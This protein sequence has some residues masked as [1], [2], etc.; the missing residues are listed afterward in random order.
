MNLQAFLDKNR[1]NYE[2]HHHPTTYTAQGLAQVEH[3]SGFL[4]AKPVIVRG[5]S[6]YAM[7]V[8]PAP[9]HV[10]LER[11]A[12]LLGERDVRLATE[13]EMSELFPDCDVGAEPPI[14]T[15]FGM[16]TLMDP[17][18]TR[19]EFL[20][21]QAGTH[22]DAVRIRRRDWEQLARPL[23]APLTNRPDGPGTHP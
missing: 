16:K 13:L 22:T 5:R 17:R 8:L 12:G 11:V 23:V 3:V 6:G 19:D 21:M 20:V 4:V 7:C 18:L 14:G 10:D 1:I 9:D 2:L 15:M